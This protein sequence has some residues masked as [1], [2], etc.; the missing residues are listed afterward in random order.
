MS[1]RWRRRCSLVVG[2]LSVLCAGWLPRAAVGDEWGFPPSQYPSANGRFILK[3]DAKSRRLALK[4][5]RDNG[6]LLR[7]SIQYPDTKAEFAFPAPVA[8][9]ITD[10]GSHVVLRDLWGAVGHGRVLIFLGPRGDV[11]SFY[12]LEQVL[13]HDEI[14]D[15]PL[16]ESSLWWSERALFFF[17]PQQ[18][19]FA[20]VTQRGTIRAFDLATGSMMKLT[21]DLAQEVRGEA[22]LLARQHL[23][24]RDPDERVTGATIVGVLGDKDSIP[25]LKR[26]LD[27]TTDMGSVGPPMCTW[28]GVQAAAGEGLAALLGANAAP[29]LKAKLPHAN[30][31]MAR[32]WVELLG[33]VGA[34]RSSPGVKKL[35]HSP[36]DTTRLTAV[37]AMLEGDDGTIVRQNP[38]WLRDKDSRVRCDAIQS[39]ARHARMQD[40]DLLRAALK[41]KE[42]ICVESA[43]DGL[44]RLNPPDLD[45]L[46]RQSLR[47]RE[48]SVAFE[49]T[50][51]L[52]RRGDRRALERVVS[53]VSSL[54]TGIPKGAGW[55]LFEVD[56]MCVML[57]HANAPGS[58]AAL[59]AGSAN[60]RPYIQISTS[61]ALA[62]L[63]D[64]Q[65]LTR[66]RGFARCED[67]LDRVHAI[68]WLGICKDRES[69]D[70]LT[71]L[72][73]DPEPL[74]RDTAREALKAIEE[75]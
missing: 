25:T 74:V 36:D 72:L 57:A 12:T 67:W 11:L 22:V 3:V 23:S 28:Y 38:Q 40:A 2:V 54:R 39:L 69:T 21:P 1:R 15:Y 16:S 59:R 70:F 35:S 60:S 17:R 26:L 5:K 29:L 27:D 8:A 58:E 37:M 34:A 49:A 24:S 18:T 56:E 65:A 7:W 41:D 30:T 42:P 64:R 63:G 73:A 48:P 53:S 47:S 19:Q 46:L 45:A 4:E 13:T 66:L 62:A 61:G 32:H 43:L 6:F 68:R 52:A 50:L 31:Q 10:D 9:Y 51:H 55:G 33:R 71:D 14:T 20:F 75:D 44:V